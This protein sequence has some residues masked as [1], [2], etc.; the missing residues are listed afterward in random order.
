MFT[1]A[2]AVNDK[3]LAFA[4]GRKKSDA[5]KEAARL[6]LEKYEKAQKQPVRKSAQPKHRRLSALILRRSIAV[7]SFSPPVRSVWIPLRARLRVMTSLRRQS[8]FV[9]I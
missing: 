5:E 2:V 7:N 4:K 8:R 3:E 9:K 6:A 1:M